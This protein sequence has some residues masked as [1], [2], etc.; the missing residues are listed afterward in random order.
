MAGVEKIIEKMN[1]QTVMLLRLKK[2]AGEGC[3]CQGCAQKDRGIILI[4]G[5]PL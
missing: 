4:A 2:P 3:I 1:R 5:N